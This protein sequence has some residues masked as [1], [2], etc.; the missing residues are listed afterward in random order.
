MARGG[1]ADPDCPNDVESIQY[2]V[3]IS[4]EEDEIWEQEQQMQVNSRVDPHSAE[5]LMRANDPRVTTTRA[6]DPMQLVRDQLAILDQQAPAT[7]QPAAPAGPHGFKVTGC[8]LILL[9]V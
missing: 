9:R 5:A 3:A 7:A 8:P 1:R 2:R 6:P 4:L